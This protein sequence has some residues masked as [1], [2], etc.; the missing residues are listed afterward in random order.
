M[1]EIM[2]RHSDNYSKLFEDFFD[3]IDTE[4]VISDNS[5]SDNSEDDD[6]EETNGWKQFRI[7]LSF[8]NMLE[9]KKCNIAKIFKKIP[10]IFFCTV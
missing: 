4:D 7:D 3:N 2:I 1:I 10:K 8:A 9:L 6:S 5:E